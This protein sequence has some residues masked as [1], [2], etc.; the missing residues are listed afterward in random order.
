MEYSKMNQRTLLKK[1][2]KLLQPTFKVSTKYIKKK[3]KKKSTKLKAKQQPTPNK[4][5][6][7]EI[8]EEGRCGLN[9]CFTWKECNKE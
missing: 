2:K 1:K 5:N 8:Y 3:K 6:N 9:I 7:N 4:N